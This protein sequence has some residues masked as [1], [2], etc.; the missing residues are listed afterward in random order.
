MKTPESMTEYIGLTDEQKT[1]L[2]GVS[3]QP[4]APEVCDVRSRDCALCELEA[5]LAEARRQ[6]DA[7]ATLY[8]DCGDC[9]I[10]PAAARCGHDQ[11]KCIAAVREWSLSEARKGEA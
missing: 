7:L 4:T 2:L 11:A 5:K 1:Q 3:T 10:C 8:A 9:S 6:I